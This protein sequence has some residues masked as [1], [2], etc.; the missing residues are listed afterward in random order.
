[1]YRR[2]A[3]LF[4]NLIL[5]NFAFNNR[6]NMNKNVNKSIQKYSRYLNFTNIF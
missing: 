1:M 6:L 4:R 5:F 2:I 3:Y